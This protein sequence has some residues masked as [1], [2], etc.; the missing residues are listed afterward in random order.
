LTKS[1]IEHNKYSDG[2]PVSSA[3]TGIIALSPLRPEGAGATPV[4][5]VSSKGNKIFQQGGGADLT[6]SNEWKSYF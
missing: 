4:K 3:N 1:T 5:S 6:L 2:P